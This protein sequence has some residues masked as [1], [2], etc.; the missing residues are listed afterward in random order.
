MRH[1]E[2]SVSE[3]DLAAIP[4][5]DAELALVFADMHTWAL[6]HPCDCEALCVC[7]REEA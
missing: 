6:A 1:G 7:E 4:K 2:L 3:H 5:D